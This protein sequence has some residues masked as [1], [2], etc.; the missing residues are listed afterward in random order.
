MLSLVYENEVLLG[1]LRDIIRT[2]PDIERALSRLSADR[3]GPKDL[4]AIRN[5][6]SKTDIIKASY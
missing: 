6:L 2:V 3:A 1:S 5:A 4:I